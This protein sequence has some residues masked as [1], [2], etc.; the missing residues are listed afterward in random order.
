MRGD[1]WHF[2]SADRGHATEGG[3]KASVVLT[4]PNMT[5]DTKQRQ[6][7]SGVIIYRLLE[8]L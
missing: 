1:V 4:P 3:W 7:G 8:P 2:G 5:P 6:K